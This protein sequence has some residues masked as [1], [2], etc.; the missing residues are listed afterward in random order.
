MEI[1]WKEIINGAKGFEKLALA[2]VKDKFSNPTWE[3]TRETRDGNKDAIAYVF[4][5]KSNNNS[6]EQWW[7]EAKYSTEC[8]YLTRYRLDA[9]IVSAL[10]ADNIKKVIFVTNILVKSKTII[11]IKSALINSTSCESVEF[12]SKYA[13]EHWLISNKDR[14]NEFFRSRNTNN[15]IPFEFNN[16]YITQEIEYYEQSANRLPFVEAA[17]ELFTQRTYICHFSAYS[18]KNQ[19]VSFRKYSKCVGIKVDKNKFTLVKGDNNLDFKITIKEGAKSNTNL[20]FYLGDQEVNSCHPIKIVSLD[21]AQLNISVQNS[22]I[23]TIESLI[24]NFKK[25]Q[26]SKY[27]VITGTYGSGKSYILKE[28]CT[29][30]VLFSEDFNYINFTTSDIANSRLIVNLILFLLFP[31]INPEEISEKYITDISSYVVNNNLTKLVSL[32]YNY[33]KLIDFFIEKSSLYD[34]FPSKLSI[35][36][37]I[38][39]IDDL[40]YLNEPC[41]S[42]L[43]KILSELQKKDTPLLVVF[44]SEQELLKTKSYKKITQDCKINVLEYSLT[45]QDLIQSI[46]SNIGDSTFYNKNIPDQINII[47]FFAF[48]RFVFLDNENINNIEEFFIRYRIFQSSEILENH[49]KQELLSLFKTNPNCKNICDKVFTSHKP[50]SLD[51]LMANDEDV[52]KLIKSGFIKYDYYNNVLPKNEIYR[53]FYLL[54]FSIEES[55]ITNF[56]DDNAEYVK[57]SFENTVSPSKLKSN[58]KLIIDKCIDKKYSYILYV[59]DDVFKFPNSKL[60]LKSR[61]NNDELFIKLYFSYAYAVHLQSQNSSS[62]EYFTEIIDYTK[63]SIN[64]ELKKICIKAL[65]EM[66]ISEYECLNY[67]LSQ[68]YIKE[69]I[70]MLKS[71]LPFCKS[72]NTILDY[73]KYHDA[74]TIKSQI[75]IDIYGIDRN[76]Q[77]AKRADL[78][79]KYNFDKRHYNTQLRVA[80]AKIIYYPDECISIIEASANYFLTNEGKHSKMYIIGKFSYYFYKMVFENDLSLYNKV[81]DFHEQMKKDQYHNYRK[82]NFAM[83][84]FCYMIGDRETGNKYLFSEIYSTREL[85]NRN[86]AFFKETTALYELLNNNINASISEL[87]KAYEKFKSLPSYGN[88]LKHN[89]CILK[90]YGSDIK[91]IVFWKGEIFAEDTYYIDPRITW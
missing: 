1:N 14:Y 50:I 88:I 48:I 69:L 40:H 2:F 66:I 33:D 32:K 58:C 68:E 45:I 60:S 44:T 91:R 63:N 85:P 77:C 12:C 80:L 31:Y 30:N 86:Y 29:K 42:F 61:I 81:V 7:M 82:R 89:I 22:T 87:K 16:L 72:K 13:L 47:E 10:L 6:K 18:P 56:F 67:E 90:K 53:K 84:S 55:N 24:K 49:I 27:T 15:I 28:L 65:W 83:A 39:F 71:I 25:N 9:T 5:Y 34:F 76:K 43:I 79:K 41:L 38:V 57:V 78:S 21:D 54:Y 36:R 4:G 23:K 37:R 17:K 35:N 20:L 52:L 3:K 64:I 73:V 19:T 51:N 26:K 11:D 75:D 70:L 46:K 8:Q 59:L 62:K 74:M